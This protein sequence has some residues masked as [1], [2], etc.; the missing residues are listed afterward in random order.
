MWTGVRETIWR[1]ATAEEEVEIAPEEEVVEETTVDEPS[2]ESEWT[3]PPEN[4][5]WYGAHN[6]IRAELIKFDLALTAIVERNG[7]ALDDWRLE[8][9]KAYV[10]GHAEH[11]RGHHQNEEDLFWPWLR[12]KF[13]IKEEGVGNQHEALMEKLRAIEEMVKALRVGDGVDGVLAEW[14]EYRA[15]VEPHLTFE[16]QNIVPLMR[17][18]FSQKDAGKKV[19]EIL[20]K[21]AKIEL[22]SFFHHLKSKKTTLEFMAQE[23]I[24]WFVWHLDFKGMR[25]TYREKMEQHIQ[26]I[27]AGE[28]A[29]KN[30]VSKADLQLS[31][32][33]GDFAWEIPRK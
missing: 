18:H 6:S 20:Q 11:V 10:A 31:I 7:N 28:K 24:P 14:R 29:T 17:K 13:E 33:A 9:V 19:G 25:T 8:S 22:G 21:A 30:L 12:T 5:G 15:L 32:N 2:F 4:D 27:L 1:M 23:G 3:F 26:Q 16:E